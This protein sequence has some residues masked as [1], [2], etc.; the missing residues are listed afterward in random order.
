MY[1]FHNNK[2]IKNRGIHRQRQTTQI[3]YFKNRF[4]L[5]FEIFVSLICIFLI[6]FEN[7]RKL[8]IEIQKLLSK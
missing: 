1:N 3:N 2:I 6:G 5:K 8:E 4:G 7:F